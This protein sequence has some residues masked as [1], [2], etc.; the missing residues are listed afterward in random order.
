MER[1]KR[2][3]LIYGM[4]EMALGICVRVLESARGVRFGERDL[5]IV[6]MV[7]EAWKENESTQRA[8]ILKLGCTLELP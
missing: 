7:T 2:A 1:S 6:W 3:R 8:V 5:V 4:S